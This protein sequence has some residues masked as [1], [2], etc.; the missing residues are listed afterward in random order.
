[1]QTFLKY[2]YEILTQFFSGFAKIFSGLVEGFKMIFDFNKYLKI[3]GNYKG[4]FSISEWVLFGIAAFILLILL[5]LVLL[6]I[7]FIFKRIF[8]FR[9]TLVEQESML[10]EI[11]E[12]NS[13]VATLVK[14]KEEILAMKVSHLGLKPGESDTIE[15]AEAPAQGE[16]GEEVDQNTSIRFAKLH[17][18]DLQYADYKV[19]NYGNSFSLAELVE[20][21][22]NFAASQLGLYYKSEM[23]RLFIS[24]LA[25]TKLVILQGISG[26]GKTS[27]A[28]AWGKFLKHDS[29]VAS[30]QPSWRDRSELFGYFNE[31][32][33]K[34]NETDI[35]KELY[36]AGYTDDIHTVI[37]DE[38]NISRVE[39]YFAEMLSILEMPNEDE[40]IVEVVS[41]GWASDPKHLKNGKIKI[42]PNCWY[43]GTIN[44]DDSTF[45]VTDKVYDRA[46]PIDIN[47]KGQVFEPTSIQ[48]QDINYSY[49]RGLFKDAMEN[50][51]MSEEILEKIE[52]MDDYVIQHFR[53]AF[54][55]RIVAH[56]KKFVPVYVACGG[57]EVDGV[58]YFIAKKILRKFEQ[59]NISF[60]RDEIDGFVD[61]L[62]RTFG[63]GKMKECIEYVLRLKKMS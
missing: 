44:N 45:M 23:I 27:L 11:G 62:N 25:S 19:Q 1:M 39:Y 28:Y 63:E 55:N 13:K 57:E 32:T 31:F 8:R 51:Q 5:I 18:V 16:N 24:A 26:T 50:N 46:M 14:E 54:G 2:F 53:I 49:L 56:M 4:D 47:D 43:I 58:D 40:W 30:V 37:L 12:L 36:E 21:F 48:A 3:T 42:P 29:C 35:L 41:S 7:I 15:G 6:G 52:R 33:K 61:F 20:L 34:F 9:K 22:R 17:N 60:I 38:M 10:D 59:L